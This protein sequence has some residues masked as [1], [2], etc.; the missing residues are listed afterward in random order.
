MMLKKNLVTATSLPSY[1][2]FR[3]LEFTTYQHAV[4]IRYNS[5]ANYLNIYKENFTGIWVETYLK[6]QVLK[7]L[8]KDSSAKPYLLKMHF[9]NKTLHAGTISIIILPSKSKCNTLFSFTI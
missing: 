3:L 2:L 7:S 1:S 6:S 5:Y 8:T 4:E 9:K